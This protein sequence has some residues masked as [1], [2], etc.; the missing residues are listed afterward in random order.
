MRERKAQTPESWK[1]Y[2]D[3]KQCL[4]EEFSL[5]TG[6]VTTFK[7]QSTMKKIL[8]MITFACIMLSSCEKETVSH[9]NESSIKLTEQQLK[10]RSALEKTTHVM[11]Q[12]IVNDKEYFNNLNE[13][14]VKGSPGCLEDRVLIKDL[15]SSTK[16]G[17]ASYVK[18]DSQFAKDFKN[19]FDM[20]RPQKV[21]ASSEISFSML[22]NPD[23]L[24]QYLED[25]NVSLYCPLPL[26]YYDENNRIP[27]IT[28]HPI[29]N[30]SVNTG[31][32]YST[33][34]LTEVTV[35][36]SYCEQHPVWILMPNEVLIHDDAANIRQKS[37]K[38]VNTTGYEFMIHKIFCTEYLGGIFDG[39][40]KLDFMRS[41]D[42]SYTFNSQNSTFQGSFYV[43]RYYLQ[44]KYVTYAKQTRLDG[45]YPI[46]HVWD[47]DWDTAN[48]SQ[49]FVLYEWDNVTEKTVT[50]GAKYKKGET[51][52]TGTV[53]KKYS[54]ANELIT[55]S[56][57]T[58]NWAFNI[59]QNGNPNWK[60][61]HP[62]WGDYYQIDGKY[63]FKINNFF[64]LT[65]SIRTY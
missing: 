14:I 26:D 25:N 3:K 37:A 43:T 59:A 18:G 11:L 19:A 50:A 16:G 46:D 40:L 29:D 65:A 47:P 54:S 8:F 41:D 5:Q 60:W 45:W 48:I 34:G 2:P 53:S 33:N 35:N 64:M 10:M 15:Y 20:I 9:S 13:R 6:C 21:N 23:S 61:V 44:R 42:N 38:A 58:R 62:T 4:T 31:Y 51:E 57:W 52:Y 56:E 49:A 39:D 24:I 22:E 17:H 36:Q 12:M 7:K 32:L 28:F 55:A 1:K 30:D 27:A 63:I